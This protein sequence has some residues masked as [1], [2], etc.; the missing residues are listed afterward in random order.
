MMECTLDMNAR[1]RLELPI[2]MI[3]RY[4][5]THYHKIV[6]FAPIFVIPVA[7]EFILPLLIY[8]IHFT[9]ET[10]L[11]RAFETSIFTLA[12]NCKVTS[13]KTSIAVNNASNQSIQ[14][15]GPSTYSP[16]PY[17]IGNCP[18]F[19]VFVFVF[20]LFLFFFLFFLRADDRN[21]RT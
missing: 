4:I 17:H 15:A 20:S 2:G 3:K 8:L 11:F 18:L 5:S 21:L 16:L 1:E 6:N 12:K 10:G 13:L 19:F 7:N 9:K 14:V